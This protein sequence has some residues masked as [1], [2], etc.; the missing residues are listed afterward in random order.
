MMRRILVAVAAA[1]LALTAHAWYVQAH[2]P[3]EPYAR[4]IAWLAREL[5]LS[6]QQTE[7][8]RAVHVAYCPG[9]DTLHRELREERTVAPDPA[10]CEAIE[11]QCARST[12][13]LIQEVSA[14]LTPVQ[15]ARY[16]ELVQPCL[17]VGF[18]EK[19]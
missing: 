3:A 9:M 16:L 5:A 11:D 15:R 7:Q 8:V 13:G 1:L 17:R 14:L 10:R 2:R 18:A 4:E 19:P 6:P 12:A